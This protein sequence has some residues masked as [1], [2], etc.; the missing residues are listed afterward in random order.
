MSES[1]ASAAATPTTTGTP[2]TGGPALAVKIDNTPSARPRVGLDRADVVYV[3]PVEAGYTRLL[4]V[5][6]TAMPA[7]V[8]P[9]R[10]ARESDAQLLGNYGPVAFAFSGASAYTLGVIAT[11]PQVNVSYDASRQGYAR[12]AGRP[13][14]YNLVGDPAALLARAGGSAPP[15]DVGL[16]FGPIP[17]A[18]APATSAATAYANSSLAFTW[19]PARQRYL[20]STEGRPELTAEGTQVSAASLVVQSVQ[21]RESSNRDV[22]GVATPVATLLGQGSVTVLRDGRQ[23]G[24]TWSRPTLAAPTSLQAADGQPLTLSTTPVWVL[25]VPQGQRVAV[26]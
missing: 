7:Q 18:G 24:G 21:V 5:F 13:A 8:G 4:A 26:Q 25:L 15:A 19:D 11:G 20:L 3:E 22:N 6:S 9:V 14:P 12:V 17:S 2:L 16:R 1:A 10:S 23:W